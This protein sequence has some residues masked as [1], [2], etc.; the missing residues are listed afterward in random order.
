MVQDEGSEA[1]AEADED[2]DDDDVSM[3][4]AKVRRRLRIV[5]KITMQASTLRL[6]LRHLLPLVID[7][8]QMDL[9]HDKQVVM[10]PLKLN[11]ASAFAPSALEYKGKSRSSPAPKA[12]SAK[13]R[14]KR[15]SGGGGGGRGKK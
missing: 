10:P 13:P 6:A 12:S 9:C 4:R 7:S 11:T 1:E 3:F 5:K 2:D 14:G 15:A 8:V